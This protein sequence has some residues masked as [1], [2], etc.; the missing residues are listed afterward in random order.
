MVLML[1]PACDRDSAGPDSASAGASPTSVPS[2]RPARVVGVDDLDDPD[3][4]RALPKTGRVRGWVKTQPVRVRP[5]DRWDEVIPDADRRAIMKTFKLRRAARCAY[6]L[7]EIEVDVLLVE[8][9]TPIDAYGLFSVLTRPAGTFMPDDGSVR[10]VEISGDQVTMSGWQGDAYVR[11]RA[12]RTS[13]DRGEAACRR[14]FIKILFDL[15]AADPPLLAQ[16]VSSA[17]QAESRVWL[18]RSCSALAEVDHP[19]LAAI[20]A[21]TMDARLGLDGEAVLSIAAVRVA[22]DEPDNLIWLIEY[23]APE[24]AAAA[25]QRYQSVHTAPADDLDRNTLPFEPKGR[26]FVGSWTAGAESI[27]QNLPKLR[28]ALPEATAA[29]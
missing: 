17:G 24:A 7:D 21:P 10:A 12:P 13:D 1:I 2:P 14:V 5:A 25:Y 8:G 22:D 23:P 6:T 29:K 28:A 3:V 11:V 9:A 26:F 15:P 4:P 27:A 16:A 19:V 18:V 20:D